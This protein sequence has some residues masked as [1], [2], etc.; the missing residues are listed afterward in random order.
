VLSVLTLLLVY[1]IA[2][3]MYED[4]TVAFLALSLGA[5]SPFFYLVSSTRLSHITTA[6][7]LALF[8]VLY[9]SSRNANKPS[10]RELFVSFLSGIALGYAFNVRSLTALGFAV[11]FCVVGS[12]DLRQRVPGTIARASAL[13]TG[14]ALMVVFT[15][16]YNAVV[17]GNALTFPFH[18]YDSNEMLGF[19]A[20]GHTFF[21]SVRNLAVSIG[22]LNSVFLGFPISLIGLFLVV[23][24]PKRFG[25]YLS[26]GILGSIAFAYLFYYSPGVSDVGPVYYYET[27]IPLLL[28]TARTAV[29]LHRWFS[30][31]VEHGNAFVPNFLAV[32][33]LLALVSFVPEQVS[34]IRRLTTQIRGPYEAVRS[35][36]VHH[37]LVLTKMKPNKGW[38]FGYTNPSPDYTDDIVYARFSDSTSNSTLLRYFQDRTA[39][40]LDG[41]GNKEPYKL[42]PV[43]PA[44]MRPAPLQ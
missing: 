20:N 29:F 30:E 34:H 41:D 25:D 11:P 38:V 14:F 33:V 37:A 8:M 42:I 28:L 10:N 26:L 32:S 17:T 12:I 43:D 39:F 22:R 35:A 36:D 9:L 18:Y 6:F 31:K 44:A 19:G 21:A 15:L 5:V 23:I 16:W 4:K 40:I 1:L 2:L 7:F 24:L 27:I 13:V 3:K